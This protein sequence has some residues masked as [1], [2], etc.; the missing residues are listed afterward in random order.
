M[1]GAEPAPE[2]LCFYN[3]RRWKESKNVVLSSI[4]H[5]RQSPL[6]LKSKNM[7]YGT[8]MASNATRHMKIKL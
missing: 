7:F 6:E 5:H 2:T 4:K 3:L 8:S 1:T